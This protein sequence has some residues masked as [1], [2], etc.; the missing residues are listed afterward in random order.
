MPTRLYSVSRAF[1]P[2]DH[3]GCGLR[4]G[5]L[6]LGSDGRY[7]FRFIWEAAAPEQASQD[8]GRLLADRDVIAHENVE[9]ASLPWRDRDRNLQLALEFGS[10][11]R[12]P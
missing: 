1:A 5:Q 8:S 2:L 12:R 6:E 10:E 7:C 4:K 3:F 11:T 9:L